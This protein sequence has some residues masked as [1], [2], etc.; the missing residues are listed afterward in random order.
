M[1]EQ[2]SKQDCAFKRKKK[3]RLSHIIRTHQT[4]YGFE[5]GERWL[6]LVWRSPGLNLLLGFVCM[7]QRDKSVG[8]LGMAETFQKTVISALGFPTV[9]SPPWARQGLNHTC[10][11]SENLW[12]GENFLFFSFNSNN[13]T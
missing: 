1:F 8:R 5:E 12:Y 4:S 2:L 9:D 10:T 6:W 7:A 3:K 11:K 13:G